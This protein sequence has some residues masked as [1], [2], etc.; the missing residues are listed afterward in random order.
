MKKITLIMFCL[1]AFTYMISAQT[2]TTGTIV[3]SNTSGLEYSA[4][5][6]IDATQVTLTLI[7]PAD[8]YLALGFGVQDMNTSGDV[9][10]YTNETNLSDRTFIYTGVA[11]SEDANQ[12]WYTVSNTVS[13]GVR[14]LVSNRVLNTGEAQ[15]YV[16]SPSDTSIDLVWARSMTNSFAIENHGPNRGITTVGITLDIENFE[17]ETNFKVYPNPGTE[18]FNIKLLDNLTTAT[19]EVYDI[20]GNLIYFNNL[21][22]SNSSI[23]IS[24]WSN[25]MYIVKVSNEDFIQTKKFIK[26]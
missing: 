14:T 23:D 26:R 20:L 24:H 25:G 5:V 19:L 1:F 18:T 10:I 2:F 3:L 7:G 21:K 16:F 6:D 8:R 15:D 12:D 13:S 9:V 17:L 4:K 11:P 22:K